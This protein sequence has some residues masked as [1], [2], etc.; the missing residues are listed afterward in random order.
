M[1]EKKDIKERIDRI[2]K[3]LDKELKG[4]SYIAT[5]VYIEDKK[6]TEKGVSLQTRNMRL[7]NT[8]ID[9]TDFLTYQ[10]LVLNLHNEVT[11][12]VQSLF[13]KPVPSKPMQEDTQYG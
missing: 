3:M 4:A 1:E 5:I 9:E 8:K 12:F 13:P 2:N 7:S 10:Q 6:V 11:T